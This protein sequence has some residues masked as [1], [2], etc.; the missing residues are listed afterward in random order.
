MDRF[1]LRENIRRYKALIKGDISDA[2]REYLTIKMAELSREVAVLDSIRVGARTCVGAG[3]ASHPEH[4][5]FRVMIDNTDRPCLVV[6]PRPGLRIV[7][8]NL[9]YSMATM[10][11]PSAAIGRNLFDVFPDNPDYPSADG[12]A[13][14]LHSLRMTAESGRPHEM[15]VQRYD[16][17]DAQGR[18]VE[19][20]WRCTNR[21]I[22]GEDGKVAWL[23]HEANDVTATM[24]GT[25]M[26][27]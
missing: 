2:E 4:R 3:E 24:T 12:V 7:D 25:V 11:E 21:P 23:L 9:A 27:S 22:F 18:F 20:H 6:D 1:V 8:M 15:A 17:R 5:L 10:S 13:N 14:L 19:K 26:V 16:V